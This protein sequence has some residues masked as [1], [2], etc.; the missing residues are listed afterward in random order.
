MTTDHKFKVT[1]S[2]LAS[3]DPLLHS[4][5]TKQLS[6]REPTP[7]KTYPMY[8]N[9]QERTAEDDLQQDQPRPT[10]IS[11][12]A[13]FRRASSKTPS[14]PLPPPRRPFPAGATPP[15]K[16]ESPSCVARPI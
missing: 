3:P 11:S 1:Y 2:T 16:N 4:T 5:S 9:G 7:G 13:T 15:G 12:W 8:I 10:P 14:T 6:A